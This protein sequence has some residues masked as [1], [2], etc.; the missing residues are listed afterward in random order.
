MTYKIL[1]E[2]LKLSFVKLRVKCTWKY[3]LG[4]MS[5]DGDFGQP[6]KFY[7]TFILALELLRE[8]HWSEKELCYTHIFIQLYFCVIFQTI[9]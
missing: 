6:Y 3:I 8:F 5:M 4:Q 1:L 2:V 7:I 9:D